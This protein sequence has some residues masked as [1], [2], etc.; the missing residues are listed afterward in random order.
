MKILI[1]T[2]PLRRELTGVGVYTLNISKCLL[3]AA[4]GHEFVFYNGFPSN[5]FRYASRSTI[6]MYLSSIRETFRKIPLGR[7]TIIRL[8]NL[9]K[10]RH[11]DVYFEPNFIP[12]IDAKFR[13]VVTTVHDL[14]F[15]HRKW[16]P[17]D[18]YEY[19]KTNFHRKINK[20]DFIITP[21]C[22][23][24]QEVLDKLGY[25]PERVVAIHH[26][27]DHSIFREENTIGLFT[28]A[29]SRR[30]KKDQNVVSTLPERFILFVG[31]LQPRKNLVNLLQAY[32]S[33]DQKIIDY[34]KLV[35]VGYES[36]NKDEIIR[37]ISSLRNHV[38]LYDKVDSN[39]QLAMI[40][41]KAIA[42]VFPSLYVGF[43]FPPIEAMACGCPTLVSNSSSLPEICG[44]AALYVDPQDVESIANGI[45][46]VVIDESLRNN[47]KVKGLKRA[48][49]FKWDKS[50]LEHLRVFESVVQ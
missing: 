41:R 11:T 16:V 28:E 45:Q 18:R 4:V 39:E 12:M 27:I 32:K 35:L 22:Y 38:F 5:K 14:S 20:S 30:F 23:V 3:N 15:L 10:L 33:L 31:A 7:R 46:N 36:W 25:N 21:S 19:F 34:C 1:N 13:R 40:Y 8:I 9:Y 44:D 47:L 6:N 37:T 2:T 48:K 50:A 24:R 26:G 17:D 43:G 29:K 42:L 49:L